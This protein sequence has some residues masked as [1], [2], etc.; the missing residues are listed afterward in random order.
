MPTRPLSPL[1][2]SA[3]ADYDVNRSFD[4]QLG[5]FFGLFFLLLSAD[6]TDVPLRIVGSISKFFWRGFI[7]NFFHIFLT[8]KLQDSETFA[9]TRLPSTN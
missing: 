7:F 4:A 3:P 9:R 5:S 6:L 1:Q 8:A 2:F